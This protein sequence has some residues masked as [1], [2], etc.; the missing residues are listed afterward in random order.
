[1]K[2]FIKASVY[3]LAIGTLVELLVSVIV[4]YNNSVNIFVWATP[5]FLAQFED[6]TLLAAFIVKGCYALIG[7]LSYLASKI[8]ESDKLSLTTATICHLL[9]ICSIVGTVGL[10]L[11]WFP[12][13]LGGLATFSLLFILIYAIIWGVIYQKT[14]QTIKAVNEKLQK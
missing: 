6:N 5:D 11:Q 8:Y 3:G 14:S 2:N 9:L 1:M 13:T 4:S 12:V 10:V 7:I